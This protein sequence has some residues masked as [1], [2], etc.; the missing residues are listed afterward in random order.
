MTNNIYKIAILTLTFIQSM[1]ANPADSLKTANKTPIR[2]TY[3]SFNY[4]K[5][6]IENDMLIPRDKTDRYFSSGVKMDFIF[7][8]NPDKNTLFAKVFPKTKNGTL[9]VGFTG[10]MN[11]FTPAEMSESMVK[12]DRPYAGWAYLG[13]TGVS[14]DFKDATRYSTEFTFGMI[15]PAT[16]QEVFQRV[17]HEVIN[18]PKPVGW[19]N[20]LPNDIAINFTFSGEKRLLKPSDNVEII[21]NVETNIGTVSNFL[22]VGSTLRVGWFEDYFR[23]IMPISRVKD[24]QLF[25]F[26]RPTIRVVADNALLQGGVFTSHKAK[27]VIPRDDLK[28]LYLNTEF[29]YS[30]TFRQFNVTYSQNLRTAEFKNAKNMFWGAVTL[31]AGF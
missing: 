2:Y 10:A 22:G 5:T 20:Q 8:E 26:A 9:H 13:L 6:K 15:G 11:M 23:N 4:V 29:G 12:G 17:V 3:P 25:V 19:E 14:N 27:Y 24:Y 21:G 18:R 28:R 1:A 16:K 7:M 31:T 30:F